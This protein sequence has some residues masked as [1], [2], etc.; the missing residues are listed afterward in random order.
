ED[1]ER[2]VGAEGG[3]ADSD[4]LREVYV[5]TDLAAS[6]WRK[7][8]SPQ[9]KEVLTRAAAVSVYLIDV[10]VATPT[11]AA[12]TGL[13]LADQSVTRGEQTTLKA[14]IEAVGMAAGDQVVELH[15]ENERGNLVKQGAQSVHLDPAAAATA[16]F[17]VRGTTGSVLQGE[18]RLLASDP[19]AFD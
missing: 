9:L 15:V 1:H 16:V 8:P 13:L 17:P 2:T 5:F 12:I 19:L 18:V 6:A 10:G 7:D 4:L 14:T 3:K 11:N